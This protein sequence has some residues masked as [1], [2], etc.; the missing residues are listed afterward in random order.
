[1]RV[2]VLKKAQK[3][4]SKLSATEVKLILLAIKDLEDYPDVYNIKKL[5]NHKPIYRKRVGSYRVLF[6]I[7]DGVIEIGRVLHRSKAYE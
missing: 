1:M 4:I 6:D 7:E 3:D 2:D 5:T